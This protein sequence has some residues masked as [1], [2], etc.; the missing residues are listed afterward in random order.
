M[1][2]VVDENV[3]IAAAAHLRELGHEV[4]CVAEGD[5][6]PADEEVWRIVTEGPALLVTR[7]HHFTNALRYDAG[8][9]L[10]IVYLRRGNLS[11]AEELCLMEAFLQ[12]HSPEEFGGRLVTLSPG[13]L[14]IR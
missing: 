4:S 1:K 6:G 3:S 14:R 13:R 8:L 11:A 10:G 5:C 2:V 7:D 12:S 9:A